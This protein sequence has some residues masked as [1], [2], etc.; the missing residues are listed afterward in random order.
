MAAPPG[1]RAAF[2]A[3]IDHTI[4]TPEATRDQVLAVADEAAAL[5]CASVCVSPVHLPLGDRGVPVC[6]VIGFRLV[7]N[8]RPESPA[9]RVALFHIGRVAADVGLIEVLQRPGRG[10]EE[11]SFA[12]GP[13]LGLGRLEP[14]AAPPACTTRRRRVCR[15]TADA[16]TA[17]R[18]M[19]RQG[20]SST[21]TGPASFALWPRGSKRPTSGCS[22]ASR[23]RPPL[24]WLGGVSGTRTLELQDFTCRP[25]TMHVSSRQVLWLEGRVWV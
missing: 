8:I 17:A 10:A 25:N 11:E 21:P 22:S 6:T 13:D 14:V 4:L 18:R 12:A 19:R 9:K 2:A 23:S 20:A 24:Q 16:Q 3:L 1:T 7:G 5:G 15:R